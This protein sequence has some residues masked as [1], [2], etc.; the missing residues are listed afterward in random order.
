MT[1]L[2]KININ[3]SGASIL[4]YKGD[5]VINSQELSGD[6]QIIKIEDK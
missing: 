1:V 6:S 5:A 2:N 3:A 4:Y